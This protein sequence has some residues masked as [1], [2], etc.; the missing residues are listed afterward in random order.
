M[1]DDRARRAC[2]L[3]RLGLR[4]ARISS[5]MA[6]I[7]AATSIAL[8]STTDVHALQRLAV[9]VAGNEFF[10][11]G[12]PFLPRGF[13]SIALLDS[14]WCTQVR[15]HA[16]SD[17][18]TASELDIARR[19]WNANTLRFQVSQPVLSGEHGVEYALQLQDRITL[20]LDA[21]FVVIVSMQDQSRA[22]GA[23]SPL[24][25]PATVA[26]WTTL[27]TST[28]LGTNNAVML[29]MFNEPNNSELTTAETNPREFTW[30]DW[31]EGGR[32]IEP[33]AGDLWTAYTPV[34]HQD[35]VDLIRT[36]LGATGV[37]IADG[38][39]HAAHLEGMPMLDDPGLGGQIGY[40][41]HPYYYSARDTTSW[42]LRWGNLAR[43]N[44]LIATEWNYT[45]SACGTVAQT[46]AP[47]LLAY[48]RTTINVGILG[49]SLDA[50]NDLVTGPALL[51][52]KCGTATPGAGYD[53]FHSYMSTF[54]DPVELPAPAGLVATGANAGVVTVGWDV[55]AVDEGTLTAYRVY[56]NGVLRSTVTTNSYLDNGAIPGASYVYTVDV[57]D[58]MWRTSAQSGPLLVTTAPTAPTIGAASAA[59]ASATVRWSAPAGDGGSLVLRYDVVVIDDTSTDPVG[60]VH[61]ADSAATSLVVNGLTNGS[62]YRFQVYAVNAVGS[63]SPSGAS[64]TVVPVA[65]RTAPG[66]PTIGTAAGGNASATVRWTAPSATGGAAITRYDVAVSN[67][68][69]GRQ[70]GALRTAAA[71]ATSLVVSGL[72][73]G[74]KYRFQVIAVNIVGSSPPSAASNTVTPAL[75]VT[76]PGAPVIGTP[77]RGST[78]GAL[79]AVATWS[80][81]A[82]TGGSPITG[83]RVYALRMSSTTAGATILATT[84]SAVLGPTVRSLSL[85]LAT[86]NYRFQVE[87]IN[88]VG[89]GARSATSSNVV[90][91]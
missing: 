39:R 80:A 49:H 62:R 83:Y 45:A 12:E 79:T 57:V 20:A 46:M 85:T 51:P 35:L 59:D 23:A 1:H 58:D 56:R 73:N 2:H 9:S 66:S 18:F 74:T 15:T 75:P 52:S 76:V 61:S 60:D 22:C 31:R 81:P 25:G 32:Q 41:V 69:T 11:D 68:S 21:G 29:E 4:R 90:P 37:L 10:V 13:N 72:V 63:S 6:T 48:M 87:A 27:L 65:P 64:N 53:F 70:V 91:R 33:S 14:E 55:P 42:D 3:T 88:A 30:V 7:I 24:P 50:Y 28:D 8:P 36:T 26:A 82:S 5:V 84:T 40:A 38:A 89:T 16:A 54:V 47:Q 78:G 71:T 43:T 19:R 86:G 67:A 44:A 77:T 17:G 34:G